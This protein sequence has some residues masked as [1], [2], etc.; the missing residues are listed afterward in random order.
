MII[1]EWLFK[2]EQSPIQNK[3]KKI[4]N[5]EPL[6]QIARQN[7][8]L[9]DKEVDKGI[10]KRM[11]NPYCFIDESLKIGFN[12]NLKSHN[13]NHA[14]SLLNILPNF[15]DI[16]IETRYFNKILKEMDTIYAKLIN[17][18][19]IKYHVL[20]SASF[21]KINEEDPRND[22]TEFFNNLNINNNLT[23]TDV[24]NIDVKSQLEHQ[25]QIQETNES[26]WIFDKI[27]SMKIIFFKTGELNGSSYVK[28]P[29]RPNGLIINEN[30]DKYCFV[31]SIL[32]SLHPC[33]NDHPNRVSNYKQFF[34]E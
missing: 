11:I 7:I 21:Y 23:E 2:E 19:R 3:I 26:G 16:G 30:N 28:I 25:I 34:D 8:E 15:P 31:W 18:Y 17:Q 33:D 4:Y 13:V 27:N 9:N 1:P 14:N 32:A 5:P 12:I 24:N 6:K 20:F 10:A 22:E 29:L